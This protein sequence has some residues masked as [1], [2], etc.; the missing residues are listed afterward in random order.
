MKRILLSL[1]IVALSGSL[2][3]SYGQACGSGFIR[4]WVNT[5]Q[6]GDQGLGPA[7][8]V[9]NGNSTSDWDAY[10][11]GPYAYSGTTVTNAYREINPYTAPAAPANVQKDGL[12]DS[13]AGPNYD[14]DAVGQDHRD[15]R[16]FAFTYDRA[17]VYFY[18]RRPKNN[19]AQVSLYYFIDINV[20]G[21]MKTGEP[22]VHLTFNNSGSSVEMGWYE[23]V[24]SNGTAAGS[25]DAVK[26]NSMVA[27]TTRAKGNNQSEWSPGFADGWSMP[28]DFHAVPGNQLPGLTTVSGIQEIMNSA[29]ISDSHPGSTETGYAVEFA[30][31]WQ[32]FRLWNANGSAGSPINYLKI[33]TWHVSLVS[34]Q[35]GISGAEDN[36]GGCCSGIAASGDPHSTVVDTLVTHSPPTTFTGWVKYIEDAGANSNIVYNQVAFTDFVPPPSGSFNP[37]AFTVT[38]YKDSNS[39]QIPDDGGIAYLY[40][41][42]ASSPPSSYVY[43]AAVDG[44]KISNVPAGGTFGFIT[45]FNTVNYGLYRFKMKPTISMEIVNTGIIQCGAGSAVVNVLSIFNIVLPVEFKSF[46]AI[47]NHSNVLLKWETASEHNSSGFAIERNNNG[48]WQQVAFVPSHAVN[49]NSDVLLS[50]QYNDFNDTKGITQYRLRQVDF[51]SKSKYSEI[52]AVRGDGQLGKTIVYP[53]PSNDGKVNVLFEDATARDVSVMDMSGHVMKQWKAL[54][55]NTIK[56]E[57]LLPGM[58]MLKIVMPDTGVQTVEKIVVAKR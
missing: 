19:T 40:N 26:G 12:R 23:A 33:F 55:S 28:G 45:T 2:Y 16:Y 7:P 47:R 3:N 20:D 6:P 41:A 43:T 27:T 58:Y 1:V 34:G 37:A 11:S 51:D 44:S 35:S 48:S 31:P 54:K 18:F 15:L 57:N 49:G 56:I 38:V 24:N 42:G 39:N 25:Y 22:V 13:L 14:K 8:I 36:A 30:V 46:S 21:F 10:I 5:G 17:N 53:N 52:R 9:I 29:T 32:Y 50:Y 4:K